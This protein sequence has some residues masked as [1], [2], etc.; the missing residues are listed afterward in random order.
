MLFADLRRTL[1]LTQ[2]EV[3]RCF[4]GGRTRQR[5]AQ[6]EAVENPCADDIGDYKEAVEAAARWRGEARR[7]A[8]K[9]AVDLRRGSAGIAGRI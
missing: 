5:V 9:L 4:R 3:A 1:H 7:L 8:R 6:I 2:E